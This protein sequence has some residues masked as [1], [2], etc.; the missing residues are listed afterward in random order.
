MGLKA[1]NRDRDTSTKIGMSVANDP[2]KG[3]GYGDTVKYD[4][5]D[6]CKVT[7]VK[8]G[9]SCLNFIHRFEI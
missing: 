1:A 5:S 6:L 3:L 4:R 8:N 9:L 7:K 2:T